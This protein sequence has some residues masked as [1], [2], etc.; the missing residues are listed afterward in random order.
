MKL[1]R[2]ICL[3]FGLVILLMVPL[4]SFSQE[5]VD[6]KMMTGPMGGSWVP[7]GG[8]IAELIQKNIPGTTVSVSP[9]G[10]IANVVGVQEEKAHIGFGN[11]S[12]SVDGVNG[13]DP[14]KA[15]TKNVM[16]LANLYPQYFQMVVLEDSGIKSPV[17]LK[18]K[19][20]CP[21]PK[22]HTGELLAQQVLQLY[23]LS[24]KDMSKVNHVSYSD[25][26]SLMKDGHA[27]GYLLGTTIPA[28]SIL[29]L[30]TTKKIRL[31][32]LPEDK[33][34][35]LQKINV[36]YL[37]RVIPKGT[38]PGVDYDVVG[39]GYFTHLVISAK[40]PEPLVY[41]ITKVISENVERLADVV[42]DMKG[43]T[44]KDLAL[45]IGVPFHPGALKYYK[46]KGVMK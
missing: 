33:I 4:I 46:E 20:I 30:A 3:G 31:L 37:K 38:Y 29:D 27:Q 18:G 6:L 44:V 43:V 21:G 12:S 28:S 26:V 17:E 9:G 14:F 2:L 5:K 19:G 39:V 16:Q 23:G 34:K 40:L 11:S 13:R 8:A 25:A 41:Q 42:K 45:D 7:L 32:S 36:G 22:G 35:E 15:P 10:G 24:Y 1:K